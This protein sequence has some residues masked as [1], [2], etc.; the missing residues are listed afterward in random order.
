MYFVLFELTVDRNLLETKGD[1]NKE[2]TYTD[3]QK[4][5]QI[6]TLWNS[7]IQLVVLSNLTLVGRIVGLEDPDPL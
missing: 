1:V 3:G 7:F 5:T 4:H 2:N 6:H